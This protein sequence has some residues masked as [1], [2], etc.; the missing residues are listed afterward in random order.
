MVKN[1]TQPELFDLADPENPLKVPC[2][3]YSRVALFA[4][5]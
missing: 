3:V 5:R 2:E 1:Q 4:V